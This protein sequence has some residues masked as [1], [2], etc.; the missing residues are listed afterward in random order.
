[1]DKL[2]E[3]ANILV[4]SIPYIKDFFGKVF[5]IKYGGSA[6]NSEVLKEKT[7]EDI[8]LMK[9]AGMNPVVVHGGGPAINEMLAKTGRKSEFI[10]G[11]RVTD[12]ETLTTTEMVL[13]GQVNKEIVML[14]QQHNIHAVGISGKD[15]MTITAGKL[16]EEKN[17]LGFVGEIVSVNPHLINILMDNDFI[18]VIAPVSCDTEGQTYN[19]NADSAASAIA[20]A[21]KAEKLIFLT[22]TP[23]ILA[24]REDESTLLTSLSLNQI[25]GYIANNTISGG[26]IPKVECAAKAIM[27]GVNSVHIL[28]GRVEH[29]VLLEVFTQKGTGTLIKKD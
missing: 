10:D 23:G 11:L 25:N 27:S 19:I 4:E 6:M 17:D 24:D 13:S 15:G 22:D 28:D 9:L 3:Q 21:L 1:M 8:S 7:I 16:S 18:P 12:A 29:S 14:F 2:T 20:I 5:V 26:M